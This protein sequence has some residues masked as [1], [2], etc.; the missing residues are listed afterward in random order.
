MTG[1]RAAAGYSL[2][3]LLVGV[4]VLG[5]VLS[6][7]L[8][9]LQ[10]S[11]QAY[12]WGAARVEAQQSARIALERMIKELREAGYDPRAAGIEG[13]VVAEP[14][15][16]VFQRDLDGDG[17]VDATSERV[18][19]LLRPGDSVLRRDAG[20]GAQPII[21]DV[22]R[23]HL[24]YFDEADHVTPDPATVVSIQIEIE[25]GSAHAAVVMRTQVTL[26]NR[27]G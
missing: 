25:V 27:R 22:R 5:L 11:L 10:A 14:T 8:G 26:R 1:W 18:T 20:G 6:A 12:R 23:F 19:F 9:I 13:I 24:T 7:V 2:P 15:R 3:E 16:V 4:A 17:V 21:N